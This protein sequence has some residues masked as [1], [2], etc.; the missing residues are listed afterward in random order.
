[1]LQDI[2]YFLTDNYEITL[3]FETSNAGFIDSE[4]Q[5]QIMKSF[6][7][8]D[9][10]LQSRGI[11]FTDIP[12]NSWYE[13]AVKYVYENNIIKGYNEYTYK[14]EDKLT[15]AMLVTVLYRMEGSP[16]VS[17]VSKFPDVQDTS[18]YYYSAV[19]WATQNGV[20]SGY[21]NGR[22]GP[23][24]Y[25]TR[26]QLSVMLNNY[27]RYKG[28]YKATATDLLK[29]KDGEKV[30]EFAKWGMNWAVGSGVITGTTYGYLNPQ[31]TATRAEAASMIYKYCLNIK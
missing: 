14:P 23:L 3:T 20:V 1:M 28:K 17:G 4:E 16:E 24:D 9:T 18:E 6:R 27:C 10:V 15:R 13:G 12:S 26:E 5:K 30:S 29:Y 7:I 25:I 22:F 21:D 8:K 31:G 19:K 11:P 2:Y